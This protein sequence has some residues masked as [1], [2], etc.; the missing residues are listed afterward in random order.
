[1]ADSHCRR[2]GDNVQG[3]ATQSPLTTY[4]GHY[5][6]V[7]VQAFHENCAKALLT[8]QFCVLRYER[9]L[10]DLL[11]QAALVCESEHLKLAFQPF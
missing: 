8:G 11:P 5:Y 2:V 10:A 6:D 7:Q 4:C 1:M 9:Q 3:C